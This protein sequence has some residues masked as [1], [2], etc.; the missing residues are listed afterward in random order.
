MLKDFV[1]HYKLTHQI[2]AV[3]KEKYDKVESAYKVDAIPQVVLIDRKG[4][5]RMVRVGAG[6]EIAAEVEEEIRKLLAEK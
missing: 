5:V 2:I 3:D 4:I 1:A 6:P